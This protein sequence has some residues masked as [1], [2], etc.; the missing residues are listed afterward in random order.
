MKFN[1][2]INIDW[3]DED[4]SLD[5]NIKNQIIDTVT[6]EV[7]ENTMTDV[8]QKVVAILE[9]KVEE[10]VTETY[11]NIINKPIKI[12]DKYGDV[13]K[14][15]DGVKEMIKEKF[16]KWL[17]EKVNSD[18]RPA[19]STYN[20]NYSRIDWFIQKHLKPLSEKFTK[21]MVQTVTSKLKSTLT[22]DMK[23][24]LGERVLE[25]VNVKQLLEKAKS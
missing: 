21:E 11:S 7:R 9:G 23:N 6:A 24:L 13:K 15:Y 14:E 10:L 2:E 16:D 19:T 1:I 17:L 8:S 3:I 25:V 20:T 22:E 18:G 5:D 12:T 4:S